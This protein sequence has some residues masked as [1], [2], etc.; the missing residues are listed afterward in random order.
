MISFNATADGLTVTAG[1]GS[2]LFDDR[3]GLA[4]QRPAR[5]VPMRAFPDDALHPAQCGGG[6]GRRGGFLTSCL[7]S[8]Q[9]K[10][11][12]VLSRYVS[13]CSWVRLRRTGLFTFL[14]IAL[15][16]FAPRCACGA[17]APR[18]RSPEGSAG[19]HSQQTQEADHGRRPSHGSY[20]RKEDPV[21]R[22]HRRRHRA[23]HRRRRGHHGGGRERGA[24][25]RGLG[26]RAQDQPGQHLGNH[27]AGRDADQAPGGA[28]RRERIVRPLLRDVP[29]RA[30]GLFRPAGRADV[31]GEH[32]QRDREVQASGRTP[33]S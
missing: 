3:Y 11:V 22:R 26:S 7:P 13:L 25:H 2:T 5:L 29:G 32:G 33:R 16:Q 9:I 24:E 6:R 31:P 30:P 28:L 1:V 19:P 10:C 20:Q 12:P 27:A 18:L 14:V 23:R 8:G 4:A 15:S 17:P 21:L